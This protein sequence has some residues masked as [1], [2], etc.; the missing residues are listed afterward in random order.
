MRASSLL[1]ALLLAVDPAAQTIGASAV[2]TTEIT[3]RT[4]TSS[5]GVSAPRDLTGGLLVELTAPG[6]FVRTQITCDHAPAT[7]ARYRILDHWQVL[8]T[9]GGP[10]GAFST[11]PHSTVLR[12]TGSQTIAGRLLITAASS[13]RN[14]S[15]V[16]G[17]VDVGDDGSDEFVVV[18]GP[19]QTL[20]LP[21]VVTPAGVPIRTTTGTAGT[22]NGAPGEWW[23]AKVDLTIAFLPAL[24]CAAQRIA[25]TC[26]PTIETAPTFAHQLQVDLGTTQTNASAALLL[27]VQPLLVPLPQ[28]FCGF[29][30]LDPVLS[31]GAPFSNGTARFVLPLPRGIPVLQFQAQG[32]SVFLDGGGA[33]RIWMTWGLG[34]ICS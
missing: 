34:L 5:K 2:S 15:S 20:E 3:V 21:L 23:S 16:L 31:F 12:V 22:T 1:P 27:G 17:R 32:A 8:G 26:G 24:I 30:T 14:G 6:M 25:D 28:P 29:L 10:H 9:Y 33:L 13:V 11:G 19:F 7:G 18:P 4:P